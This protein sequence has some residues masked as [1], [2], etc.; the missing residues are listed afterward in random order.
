M[1]PLHDLAT[2]DVPGKIDEEVTCGEVLAEDFAEV[3]GSDPLAHEAHAPFHPGTDR[4]LEGL[5]INDRNVVGWHLDVVKENRQRAAGHGAKTDKQNPVGEVDHHL[6][7]VRVE[8]NLP[9]RRATTVEVGQSITTGKSVC[10]M[11]SGRSRLPTAGRSRA[12]Q[13]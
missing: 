11:V 13:L 1:A 10:R 6:S 5:E 7:A 2:V 9:S 12:C 8:K 3:I 4:R